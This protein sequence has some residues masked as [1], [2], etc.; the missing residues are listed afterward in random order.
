MM[1]KYFVLFLIITIIL[2]LNICSCYGIEP[3]Y[4]EGDTEEPGNKTNNEG[5]PNENEDGKTVIRIAGPGFYQ[6]DITGLFKEFESQHPEIKIKFKYCSPYEP[7]RYKEESPPDIIAVDYSPS[8]GYLFN[9]YFSIIELAEP[10]DKY[11]EQ[12][13]ESVKHIFPEALLATKAFGNTYCIPIRW[14]SANRHFR[15][16]GDLFDELNLNSPIVKIEH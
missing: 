3:H 7:S 1:P 15:F 9:Y 2:L 4:T 8:S 6:E 10:L 12:D 16:N 11:I 5:I 14:Q 13:P